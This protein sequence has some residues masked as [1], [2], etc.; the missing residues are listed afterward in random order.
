MANTNILA[1]TDMKNDEIVMCSACG[2]RVAAG[3]LERYGV[4]VP[5]LCSRCWLRGRCG[6]SVMDTGGV[7]LYTRSY[8][9][10][11]S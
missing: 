1:N 11:R 6:K 7:H 10:A 8:R 4:Y 3:Y 9:S 2:R 5:H